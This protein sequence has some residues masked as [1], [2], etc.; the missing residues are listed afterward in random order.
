VGARSYSAGLS[1]LQNNVYM[2]LCA[3]LEE[4]RRMRYVTSIER[5]GRKEGLQQGLQ[6]EASVLL[7]KLL[8]RRFGDLPVWVEERL[9]NAS[10]EELEHWVERVL[11][12]PVFRGGVHC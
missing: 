11:D 6:Q 9:A 10:R 8:N 12:G 1:A 3:G 4:E 5:L 7:K 2:N